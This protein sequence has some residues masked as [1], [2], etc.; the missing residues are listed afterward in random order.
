MQT[1]NQII[2]TKEMIAQLEQ[3][4]GQSFL[5]LEPEILK[6]YG[7]DETEDFNFPPQIVLKPGT[8]QE[9][10]EIMKWATKYKIPVTPI[11]GKTGLSG[12][13]LCVHGGIGLSMERF[14][15]IIEIDEK[16][17]QVITQPG[18]ITQV[19]RDTVAKKI[20]FIQ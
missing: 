19:L 20:F 4:V 12:G 16:N 15:S 9:I 7:H 3:I 17:L 5:F 2:I 11:G 18:V 1:G 13:A 6:H 10:S 8:T 14:N